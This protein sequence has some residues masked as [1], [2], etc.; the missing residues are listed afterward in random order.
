MTAETS[1]DLTWDDVL[2]DYEDLIDETLDSL[3][4]GRPPAFSGLDEIPSSK[5]SDHHVERFARLLAQ[6]EEAAESLRSALT[7][8]A[9]LRATDRDR[10]QA[11]RTYS[12]N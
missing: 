3:D 6:A 8:N 4:A 11:R 7:S 1:N 5:P 12:A 2:D 9:E 10:L